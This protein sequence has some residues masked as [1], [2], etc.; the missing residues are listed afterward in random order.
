MSR[1]FRRPLKLDLGPSR[2]PHLAAPRPSRPARSSRRR[3][4]FRRSTIPASPECLTISGSPADVAAVAGLLRRVYRPSALKRVAEHVEDAKS[5][6]WR[7]KVRACSSGLAMALAI[8]TATATLLPA[9]AIGE[10]PRPQLS[11]IP[12]L[13]SPV[14]ARALLRMSAHPATSSTPRLALPSFSFPASKGYE[15]VVEG[16]ESTVFLSVFRPGAT[17]SRAASGVTHGPSSFGAAIT[18]YIARG[19]VSATGLRAGFADLGRVAVHF[20]PS[21]RAAPPRG[22][23]GAGRSL[24]PGVFRGEIDFEGEGGYTTAHIHRARGIVRL[25]GASRCSG[26][27][28]RSPRRSR[29][30]HPVSN[31]RRTK[32]TSFAAGWKSALGAT[33]FSAAT[34]GTQT[35]RYLAAT[36]QSAGQI[37]VYRLALAFAPS[38]T[39]TF[40][41]AL[42]SASLT[43]PAP[44]SGTGSFQQ[45]VAGTR[46]WTGP[47]AVSFPGAEDTPLTGPQ[48]T[49]QLTT[50]W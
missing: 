28:T 8:A 11:R 45:G 15:I 47:L 9:T 16:A 23:R 44:F 29:S 43:P 39:F 14:D 17:S 25:L 27:A 13:S 31:P 20:H 26:P 18:T 46:S 33:L 40:D 10:P 7:C 3:L 19:E 1:L 50:S 35:A 38:R 34:D 5:S 49:T 41:S 6:L 48:F 24:V 30:S 12:A 22:C 42:S 21:R 36:E 4:T 2:A 32:I 37:A